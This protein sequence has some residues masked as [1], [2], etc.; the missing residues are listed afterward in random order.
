M[1][2]TESA[3]YTLTVTPAPA[4]QTREGRDQEIRD[5][6]RYRSPSLHHQMMFDIV[7]A[8]HMQ[9]I[10]AMLLLP[11]SRDRSIAL[12]QLEL[13]RMCSNKAVAL[14]SEE[15]CKSAIERAQGKDIR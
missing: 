15:D 5:R 13:T 14:A 3:E 12:T 8:A 4:P 11:E 2:P 1:Q 10:E 6:Q 7:A 9:S